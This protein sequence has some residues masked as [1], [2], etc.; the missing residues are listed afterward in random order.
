MLV[1]FDL[2]ECFENVILK[3]YK[4]CMISVNGLYDYKLC[5]MRFEKNE[6]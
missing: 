3:N 2:Q 4:D 5:V 1:N 6:W